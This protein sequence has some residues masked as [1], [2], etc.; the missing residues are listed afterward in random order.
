MNEL[1]SK[2]TNWLYIFLSIG[3]LILTET[4]FGFAWY[5]GDYEKSTLKLFAWVVFS[6]TAFISYFFFKN[7][8]NE[9]RNIKSGFWV[10]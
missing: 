6:V 10:V 2:L 9:N 4:I 8:T 1:Y 5:G 7:I 3:S